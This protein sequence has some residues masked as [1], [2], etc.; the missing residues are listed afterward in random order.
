VSLSKS[1][2][3]DLVLSET[4]TKTDIKHCLRILDFIMFMEVGG[5]NFELFFYNPFVPHSYVDPERSSRD[6]SCGPFGLT[7]I[8]IQDVSMINSNNTSMIERLE[9]FTTACCEKWPTLNQVEVYTCLASLLIKAKRVFGT[10]VTLGGLGTSLESLYSLH[11]GG[12]LS[13]NQKRKIIQY[14]EK[15]NRR[16]DKRHHYH[17]YCED[18]L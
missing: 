18:A 10:N 4:D 7:T 11:F 14:E 9:S 17:Y 13:E 8:V 16:S 12:R 1:Y 2:I 6:S 3:D 5:K 15:Y